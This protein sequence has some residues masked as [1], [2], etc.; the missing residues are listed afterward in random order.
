MERKAGRGGVAV[1][2]GGPTR[3]ILGIGWCLIIL[4]AL[5]LVLVALDRLALSAILPLVIVAL[6]G[7]VWGFLP[8]RTA[9]VSGRRPGLLAPW[10]FV[11]SVA[12]VAGA[13]LQGGFLGP[14]VVLCLLPAAASRF[15]PG[16]PWRALAAAALT[17][18]VLATASVLHLTLPAGGSPLSF[19]LLALGLFAALAAFF[20]AKVW[21]PVLARDAQA[22][23]PASAGVGRPR[24]LTQRLQMRRLGWIWDWTQ[25]S[26]PESATE[27]M[28]GAARIKPGE[29]RKGLRRIERRIR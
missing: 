12:G 28:M 27:I 10:F 2:P 23:A 25:R 14:L 29:P 15:E 6:A 4:A 24:R 1:H 7:P 5:A 9:E 22:K 20:A 26:R 8:R 21:A 3:R 19:V 13:A 16:S 11:W 18:T 17:M